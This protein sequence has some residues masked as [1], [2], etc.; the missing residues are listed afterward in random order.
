MGIEVI[1]RGGRRVAGFG[2][3]DAVAPMVLSPSPLTLALA[4]GAAAA[5][6][7]WLIEEVWSSVWGRRRQ[8]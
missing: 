1:A 8:Q 5:A 3:G 4:G 2:V 6:T 7:G